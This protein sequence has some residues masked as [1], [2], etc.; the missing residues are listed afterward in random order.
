MYNKSLYA[1]A[2]P[3]FPF[4]GKF[5]FDYVI[6]T[7]RS[8]KVTLLLEWLNLYVFKSLYISIRIYIGS[9]S[10]PKGM[11][12]VIAYVSPQLWKG[13]LVG[14]LRNTNYLIR[15]YFSYTDARCYFRLVTRVI[16]FIRRTY[17][18]YFTPG[19]LC[20]R[21]DSAFYIHSVSSVSEDES[22]RLDVQSYTSRKFPTR[23]TFPPVS[24]FV[25][26]YVFNSRWST[27]IAFFKLFLMFFKIW[28]L[29]NVMK[30]RCSYT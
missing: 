21:F 13:H 9:R 2:R 6:K 23:W 11:R 17:S 22:H 18:T 30:T 3:S 25:N 10:R 5:L 15:I 12:S 16:P 14:Q 1:L 7:L 24:S 27:C 28:C 29:I 19:R 4:V 8:W 26:W 20:N